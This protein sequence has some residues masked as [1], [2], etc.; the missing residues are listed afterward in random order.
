M[1]LQALIASA[2]IPFPQEQLPMLELFFSLFQEESAKVNLTALKTPDDIALKL[3]VD[4]LLLL[5]HQTFPAGAKVLD[6]G[7]GGGFPGLPLAI[8]APTAQFTLMDATGK[9]TAAIE[10]MVKALHL[11]NVRVVH[12][13]AEDFSQGAMAG[14][15]DFVVAKALAK[16]PQTISWVLPFVK[17][18][19][20]AILYQGPQVDAEL[21]GRA[22]QITQLGGSTPRVVT[23][24]LP[25][26][27]GER[28]FV[29][30]NKY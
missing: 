5:K 24:A 2:N 14:A 19:G 30:I 6:V 1:N 16:L 8:A 17:P 23:D 29:I 18:G 12:G 9:K 13:R 3:I 27:A 25:N 11:S 22:A 28:R 10:R 20:S 4:S 15:F 21:P 26:G 7:S